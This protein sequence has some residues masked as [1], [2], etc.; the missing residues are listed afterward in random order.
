MEEPEGVQILVTG[1]AFAKIWG[2]IKGDDG[3]G[4]WA[5]WVIVIIRGSS[6]LEA[7]RGCGGVWA[8]GSGP[9]L[10]RVSC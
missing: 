3:E 5:P 7:R 9:L 2:D 1:A 4:R 10:T 8:A 6:C